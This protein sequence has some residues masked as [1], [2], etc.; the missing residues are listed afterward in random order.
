MKIADSGYF[1]K[2]D[3]E[4]LNKVIKFMPKLIIRNRLKQAVTVRRW[5]KEESAIKVEKGQAVPLD[6]IE[7]FAV[8]INGTSYTERLHVG[9][10]KLASF[11]IA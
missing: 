5:G 9:N 3:T 2:F 7:S 6:G 11:L 10:V 4:R 8:S 1:I